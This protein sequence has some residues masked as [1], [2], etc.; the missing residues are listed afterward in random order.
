MDVARLLT[1]EDAYFEEQL[2]TAVNSVIQP[3]HLLGE[4]YAFK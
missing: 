4:G 1:V 3:V 2:E